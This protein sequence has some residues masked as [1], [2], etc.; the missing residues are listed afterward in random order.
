MLKPLYNCII[1]HPQVGK[2]KIEHFIQ[3]SVPGVAYN[4]SITP[5]HS[6]IISWII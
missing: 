3:P 5:L 6:Q 1:K 4:D 2:C